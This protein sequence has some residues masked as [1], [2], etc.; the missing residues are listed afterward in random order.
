MNVESPQAFCQTIPPIIPSNILS[1]N[2]A[3]TWIKEERRKRI[4]SFAVSPGVIG[5]NSTGTKAMITVG[6]ANT[7]EKM[8]V[9]RHLRI[10]LWWFTPEFLES[11]EIT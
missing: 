1:I 8:N 9:I 4:T 6:M 2:A 7:R 3:L 5:K 11:A 10:D